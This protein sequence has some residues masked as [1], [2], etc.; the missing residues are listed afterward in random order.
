MR[1]GRQRARRRRPASRALRQ[2]GSSRRTSCGRRGG[3]RRVHDFD[4]HV[5][6]SLNRAGC[7]SRS[8]SDGRRTRRRA[9]ARMRQ[10]KAERRQPLGA[11]ALHELEV[12]G[13]VD[14]AGGVGV[15]VVNADGKR[16]GCRLSLGGRGPRRLRSAASGRS[17]GT[18]ARWRCGRA[19]VRCRKPCWMRYGSSTSSIV[20]RSSPIAAARLSTP[21]GPPPNLSST[22]RRSLRSITSRPDASTSSIVSAASATSRVTCAVGAALRR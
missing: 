15:L 19:S 18:T 11:R 8:R 4:R 16:K 5:E 12:V 13:V 7:R 21:T 9:R 17:G 22:A 1:T 20:S 6:A 14:D 2:H 10:R 3:S